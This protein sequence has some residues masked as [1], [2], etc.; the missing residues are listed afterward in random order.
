[1]SDRTGPADT[2][3]PSPRADHTSATASARSERVAGRR[4]PAGRSALVGVAVVALLGAAAG[5]YFGLR[6]SG[7]GAAGTGGQPSAR[8]GAALATDPDR[9]Q[10]ILF[11][12][13]TAV[14]GRTTVSGD[15]WSWNGSVW[16][17]LSPAHSPPG[18]AGAA[19][20]WDPVSHRL[21]LV[22]GATDA[23]VGAGLCFGTVSPTP[24]L[25]DTWAWD[26]HDWGQIQ[27]R[28]FATYGRPLMATD[29]TSSRIVAITSGEPVSAGGGGTVVGPGA[30][31]SGNPSAGLV[32]PGVAGGCPEGIRCLP[33]SPP[34]TLACPSPPAPVSC[35]TITPC[36]AVPPAPSASCTP[37]CDPSICRR[38]Q[39]VEPITWVFDG[40]AWQ[41]QKA[42]APVAAGGATLVWSPTRHALVLSVNQPVSAIAAPAVDTGVSGSGSAPAYMCKQNSVCPPIRGGHRAWSYA[43]GQWTELPLPA[44]VDTASP[45]RALAA[46]DAARND[47]VGFDESAAATWSGD[48]VTWKRA[49]PASSPTSRLGAA[50]A[51]DDIH[52]MVVLV[53]GGFEE[54]PS[55]AQGVATGP[56]L[57]NDTWTWDGTNWTQRGGTTPTPQPSRSPSN[58]TGAPAVVPP[59]LPPPPGKCPVGLPAVTPGKADTQPGAG[60]KGALLP[61]ATGGPEQAPPPAATAVPR[62]SP[63]FTPGG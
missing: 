38:P 51:S 49:H 10:V 22:G 6:G 2:E 14:S 53:G 8:A 27:S 33:P 7:H 32:T 36:S 26:G 39:V 5:T 60:S 24:K 59:G 1:M 35:V 58:V 57:L 4:R 47:V 9:Q 63:C 48:A 34:T 15:T 41:K 17:A 25:A 12:G 11:G 31:A 40:S 29:T 16:T 46:P 62:P 21:I 28:E 44:G 23:C 13:A 52:H 42:P 30:P 50:M 45:F 3:S 54:K 55:P 18:R 61:S 37:A 20:A 19:M 43:N 56:T